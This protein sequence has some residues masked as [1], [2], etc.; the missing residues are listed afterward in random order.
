[1]DYKQVYEKWL[2]HPN[3]N[4]DDRSELKQLTEE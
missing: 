1:M 4:E 3:L 2:N